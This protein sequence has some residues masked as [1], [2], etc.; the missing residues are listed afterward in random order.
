M[1]SSD[2]FNRE[3]LYAYVDCH[4]FHGLEIDLALRYTTSE[5]GAST[6]M[7]PSR[8]F[9]SGFRL[10]GEGKQIDRIME[11]FAERYFKDNPNMEYFPSAG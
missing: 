10:P 7:T 3:V 5:G 6:H 11:K 1:S 9:L 8:N 2:A 4:N